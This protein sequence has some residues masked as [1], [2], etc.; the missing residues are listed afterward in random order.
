MSQA[1]SPQA[2][3]GPRK[4]AQSAQTL[5]QYVQAIRDMSP[6]D[7]RSL[8]LDA[9][10][11]YPDSDYLW[12]LLG[13]CNVAC[14]DATGAVAAYER[15]VALA[16]NN[17]A[18]RGRLGD[19]YSRLGMP[20]KSAEQFLAILTLDNPPP[21]WV[22]IGLG[23]VQEQRGD[24]PSAIEQFRLA[25]ACSPERSE[26]R[27]RLIGLYERLGRRLEALDLYEERAD[28]ETDART[29]LARWC[30]IAQGWE[31]KGDVARAHAAYKR[32]LEC[33][34]SD[35]VAELALV[36]TS[37]ALGLAE[38][39]DAYLN[40][41]RNFGGRLADGLQGQRRTHPRLA[42]D[43]P[44]LDQS[45]LNE[46]KGKTLLFVDYALPMYD[47]YAGSRTNYMYLRVLLKMGLKVMYLPAD[48]Q[49]IE[50][51]S[52]ELKSLGVEVLAGYWFQDNWKEWFKDKGPEI[53]YA[54]LHK[55]NPAIQFFNA[56][57]SHTTAAI[58]Y[59]CHDLHYLRLQR[60]AELTKDPM[61]LDEANFFREK[62]NYLFSAS[63]ALLTFSHVEEGIIKKDFPQK[64]VYT[65]PL[66]FYEEMP[67]PQY[68]FSKR[69]G[70]LYVGGFGHTPNRDA[71]QWF[72]Q[73]VLPLVLHRIP[74]M[75]FNVV[76]AN[77][78]EE[79]T[80]LN[81][82]NVKILGKVSEETLQ[83]LYG[84]VKLAVIP[85][86]VGAG[87]KGKVIE[88]LYHGVPLVSTSIGLE[89][90]TGIGQVATP[91]DDPEAFAAEILTLYQDEAIWKRRSVLCATFVAEQCTAQKTAELIRDIFATAKASAEERCNTAKASF[92]EYP[93]RTIAFY[94]PQY[95]PFPENDAWWGKGFTEWRNVC[96]AKPLFAGHY[97]P[98]LPGD[99]GFYDL[100]LE[101]TRV[102]QADLASEYGIHGF[103]YYHYWFNGK[104]LLERPAEAMLASGKPDFPFCL[105]W[106]NENW[107][108]CWDGEDSSI[109][110]EQVYSEADDRAH[111]QDLIRFFTD[112]RYIRVN[113]KPLF[114]VYRTENMPD[115]ARTA[116][117]WREEARKAGIG[118]LYLVRVESKR[119]INPHEIGFDA[120]LEFAP[121]WD[122]MGSV[123]RSYV[124]DDPELPEIVELPSAVYESNYTRSYVAL[125]EQMLEKT[126]PPYPWFRCVTPA[127]D[128]SARRNENAVILLG[129]SPA[130]Y[131]EWLENII[132]KTI[133]SNHPG[134]RLI[135]VNAWNEWAEG[136]HL[137]PCIKWRRSYLEATK[138][139]I[140]NSLAMCP[141]AKSLSHH[142]PN[143]SAVLTSEEGDHELAASLVKLIAEKES[144]KS[145]IISFEDFNDSGDDL[146]YLKGWA[147]I[148]DDISTEGT[149]IMILVHKH[150]DKARLIIPSKRKR[151]EITAHFGNKCNYDFSGFEAM[152]NRIDPNAK[153]SVIIK[154]NGEMF[155]QAYR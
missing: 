11:A 109:L 52:T 105:C 16:P 155:W 138:S 101:E 115:S 5:D 95:H 99:L 106:A 56:I 46:L 78:P 32:A 75:V 9:L 60:Q 17:V 57:L 149:D 25:F 117:V 59:Q 133:V 65:V 80:A 89:G 112:R 77:P 61:L 62:E 141:A 114:L 63:D 81:S 154:R 76:G 102:A 123:V 2:H 128:N 69:R 127:W 14:A 23:N 45:G 140:N 136:N 97:Q 83:A 130:I 29:R 90:I 19:A 118:E 33:G 30:E 3:A 125:M 64:Q 15:A 152:T 110:M 147:A 36:R 43:V 134:E 107:T 18:N 100:R 82:A 122:R 67:E 53:D 51:Y 50:P 145:I 68:D 98:H 48:F 4:T 1:S 84:S 22:Y 120:A 55:P 86:R 47:R 111:I 139:G 119:R 66:F 96:K 27:E 103:C 144:S 42:E 41:A 6:Q 20:D 137:E 135:F 94:L 131:Q 8:C 10:Q 121:D 38:E 24:L 143:F 72:C 104:R 28:E 93:L 58:I 146:T 85:L 73:E 7:S 71:V 148:N 126:Q 40:E 74:D 34:C 70:L 79:I 31:S 87:V 13:E 142:I 54:F 150:G 37:R 35:G 21:A 92:D 116:E 26:L 124:P 153:V 44:K 12:F 129:S 108:R 91:K 151:P 49:H 39:A 113:G 88:T 132:K